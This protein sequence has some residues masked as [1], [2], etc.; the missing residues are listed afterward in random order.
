[1]D[2]IGSGALRSEDNRTDGAKRGEIVRRREVYGKPKL[3]L[4]WC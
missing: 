1:M 3:V 2:V 4:T